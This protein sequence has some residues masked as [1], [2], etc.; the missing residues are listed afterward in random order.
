MGVC[1]PTLHMDIGASCQSHE[2]SNDPIHKQASA[3]SPLYSFVWTDL[4]QCHRTTPYNPIR[5]NIRYSKL[6]ENSPTEVREAQRR[7]SSGHLGC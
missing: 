5:L 6:Y 2:T 1:L 4:L 3:R 7:G